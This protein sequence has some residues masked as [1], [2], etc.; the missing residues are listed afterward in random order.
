MEC[1]FL[2]GGIGLTGLNA[3]RNGDFQPAEITGIPVNQKA[4]RLHLLLGA[5]QVKRMERR[6]PVFCSILRTR[7]P[8]P[9][10]SLTAYT[11][12][13]VWNQR[14]FLETLRRSQHSDLL[15]ICSRYQWHCHA[16]LPCGPRKSIAGGRDFNHR[17]RFAL[18]CGHA[19]CFFPLQWKAA[20]L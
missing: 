9:S 10:G 6:W 19:N 20:K 8:A 7:I 16:P 1:L 13:L 14:G 5:R 15:G 2:G 18:Q 12:K 17:L 3:A 4:S 11:S